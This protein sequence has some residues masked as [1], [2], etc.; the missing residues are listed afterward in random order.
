MCTFS[1][2][3]RHRGDGVFLPPFMWLTNGVDL[4]TSDNVPQIPGNAT[5]P[6]NQWSL[7]SET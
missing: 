5:G 7:G 3:T 1:D 6:F 2:P 4:A